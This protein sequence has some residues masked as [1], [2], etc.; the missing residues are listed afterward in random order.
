MSSNSDFDVSLMEFERTLGTLRIDFPHISCFSTKLPSEEVVNT[1]LRR[2]KQDRCH[3]PGL[4]HDCLD[5]ANYRL[6]DK[7]TIQSE[8]KQF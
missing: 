8:F 1:W 2:L 7:I 6:N 3:E 5:F 4:D